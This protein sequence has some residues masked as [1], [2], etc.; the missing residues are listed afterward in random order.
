M[1]HLRV[2]ISHK[3]VHTAEEATVIQQQQ[4]KAKLDRPGT[5]QRTPKVDFTGFEN[6]PD[7]KRLLTRY[8]TLQAQLQLSYALTLEPGPSEK[9]TWNKQPLLSSLYP[10]PSQ[11]SNRGQGRG[12]GRGRGR[13]DQRG[14]G[15]GMRGS[16][17]GGRGMNFEEPPEDREQG[18]W[19]QAKGDKEALLA[20]KKMRMG[21][22]EDDER[23]EGMRE[24]GELCLIKFGPESEVKGM[25]RS[26]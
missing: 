20:I 6:D 17:R 9:W 25:D 12:R 8:P 26:D 16:F 24:F 21:G 4:H 2:E 14:G 5:T 1:S 13:Y 22:G 23:A 18:S 19:T 3:Q 15:R 7:F 10:S 11:P